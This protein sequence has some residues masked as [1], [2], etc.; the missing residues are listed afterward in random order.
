M[1]SPSALLSDLAGTILRLEC[2]LVDLTPTISTLL[3]EHAEAQPREGESVKDAWQRAGF[4]I[5]VLSTGGEKVEHWVRDAWLERG[6][7]VVIDYGP[8]CAFFHRLLHGI[9]ADALANA[10]RPP[11][12]SSRTSAPPLAPPSSPSAAQPASISFTSSP[13]RSR[14]FL[15]AASA[16]SA[17]QASRLREG[18]SRSR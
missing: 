13:R 14:S 17:S 6:V 16:R 4:R 1:T 2:T 12:A 3:F 11:S 9:T 15:L 7:R 5:K 10:A 8:R 18:T